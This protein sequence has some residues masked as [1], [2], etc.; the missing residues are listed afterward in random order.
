[1]SRGEVGARA[2]FMVGELAFGKK[3][4]AGATRHFQ[5]VMFGFGGESAAPET[6]KWQAKAGFEVG[7]C[8]EV[9][10]KDAQGPARAGLLKQAQQAYQYVIDKHPQDELAGQAKKR[11]EELSKL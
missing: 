9:Q 8:A 3:D 11:L 1:M 10:I 5:R 4:F 6:K 2:R 7:R